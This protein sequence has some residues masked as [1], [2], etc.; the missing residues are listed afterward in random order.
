VRSFLPACYDMSRT[1]VFQL[2]TSQHFAWTDSTV[3]LNWLNGNHRRFKTFVGNRVSAILD[4][5][6]PSRWNHVAGSENPADCASRGIS[7]VE[8]LEHDL[9]WNGPPWLQL[10][11]T[12]WPKQCVRPHESIPEEVRNVCL[13]SLTQPKEPIVPLNCYSNFSHLRR[14]TAWVLRF[15]SNCR[16]GHDRSAITSSL[17]VSELNAAKTYWLTLSQADCFAAEI[18][19]LKANHHLPTDNGL[20]S[21]CPFLDSAGVLR[22]GGRENNSAMAF[23]KVHP[24]ILHGK[25]PITKLMVETEHLR[26]LHAGPTLLPAS[27]G[28][29]YH[30]TAS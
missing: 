11:P 22:V 3:V 5:V 14:V 6:P 2:P 30:S 28:C 9:W 21:L 17:T 19:A 20:I 25:H 15:V 12:D 1:D 7:P 10:T 16:I 24:V 26:L 13:T 8:L 29:C 27:I 23:A 18:A 4:S